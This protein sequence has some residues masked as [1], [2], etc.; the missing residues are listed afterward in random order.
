MSDEQRAVVLAVVNALALLG[1]IYLGYRAAEDLGRRRA[2]GGL[3]P[4]S[5]FT[6]ATAL[7]GGFYFGLVALLNGGQPFSGGF[8]A[9]LN[10][11]GSGAVLWSQIATG[12]LAA[13]GLAWSYVSLAGLAPS[14][15]EVEALAGLG[16]LPCAECGRPVRP[17][18]AY[19]G[20]CGAPAPERTQEGEGEGEGAG[21]PGVAEG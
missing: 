11:P 14:P 7:A 16:A 21:E 12:A 13:G 1:A 5:L 15:T 18:A 8:L 9:G 20:Y 2:F 4:L 10:P 6:V 3:S 19:C 17:G